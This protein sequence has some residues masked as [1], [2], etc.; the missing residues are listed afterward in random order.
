MTGTRSLPPPRTRG[1]HHVFGGWRSCSARMASRCSRC[2]RSTAGSHA[3]ARRRESSAHEVGQPS[4]GGRAGAAER[5]E[6]RH[7]RQRPLRLARSAL[8]CPS[9]LRRHGHGGRGR[10]REPRRLGR[11]ERTLGQLVGVRARG[12]ASGDSR[13]KEERVEVMAAIHAAFLWRPNGKD[14][15]PRMVSQHREWSSAGKIDFAKN[16]LSDADADGFRD[17]VR[18][19]LAKVDAEHRR[20][21]RRR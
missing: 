1:S 2:A 18:K 21:R 12:R 15:E 13:V 8:P 20:R 4:H 16:F 17:L 7:R 3:G 14:L 10:S 11:V 5:A 19:T 9:G 6:S